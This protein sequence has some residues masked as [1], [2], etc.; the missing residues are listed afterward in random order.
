MGASPVKQKEQT[1]QMSTDK[2]KPIHT[3]HWNLV[4]QYAK[5]EVFEGHHLVSNSPKDSDSKEE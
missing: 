3:E 2:A 4:N 1:E 5:P